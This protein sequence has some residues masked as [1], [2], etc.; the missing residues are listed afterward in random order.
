MIKNGYPVF[1]K[2]ANI[3]ITIILIYINPNSF[4]TGYF[5]IFILSTVKIT[6]DIT[7]VALKIKPPNN[8]PIVI[9][10][11]DD[12]LATD[13]DPNIS[14]APF[15]IAIKVTAAKVGLNPNLL[16]KFYIPIAKYLSAIVATNI[17]QIGKII[18]RTVNITIAF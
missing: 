2:Y 13:S 14:G 18:K 6:F 16:D 8:Y 10:A 15:A 12:L 17:K 5:G 3:I 4:I 1:L 7:N 11:A 9:K